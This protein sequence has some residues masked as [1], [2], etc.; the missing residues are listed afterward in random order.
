MVTLNHYVIL[1]GILFGL[2]VIGFATRRNALV[3]FMCVEL[4]LNAVNLM[5]TAFA[6]FRADMAGQV[7]VLF[8][9]AVAAAE[10]AVG[11]AILIVLFRHVQDVDVNKFQLLKW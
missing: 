1:A 6:E 4:M 9:Y 5:L 10:V 3:L 7:M 2:G 11:L 8:I